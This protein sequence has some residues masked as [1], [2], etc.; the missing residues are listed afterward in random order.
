MKIPTLL[1]QY[2]LINPI[3]SVRWPV[4]IS[5][6]ELYMTLWRSFTRPSL[7]YPI[8]R[9]KAINCAL[10]SLQKL[11]DRTMLAI[12]SLKLNI[13][14]NKSEFSLIFV[15]CCRRSLYVRIMIDRFLKNGKLFFFEVQR[16]RQCSLWTISMSP[17][18]SLDR[19]IVIY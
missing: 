18:T 8:D 10:T 6:I 5:T 19:Y 12:D 14:N 3:V 13:D 11:H 15:Y 2:L 7:R 16:R 1:Q 17:N 9:I 4:K